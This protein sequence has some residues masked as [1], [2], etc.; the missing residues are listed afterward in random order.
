[1]G[2]LDVIKSFTTDPN[3]NQYAQQ[4][5]KTLAR[6]DVM[7]KGVA[8][9][10]VAPQN[11]MHPAAR[12]LVYAARERFVE[13]YTVVFRLTPQEVSAWDNRAVEYIQAGIQSPVLTAMNDVLKM[14]NAIDPYRERD[15]A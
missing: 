14:K 1:M 9:V 5:G 11:E 10:M 8:A 13:D 7:V 6:I 4:Y 15:V 3:S 12:L 2:F